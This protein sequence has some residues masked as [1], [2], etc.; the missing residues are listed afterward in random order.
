VRKETTASG[1][2]G[3]IIYDSSMLPL[4]IHFVVDSR[5]RE[6]HTRVGG[7][8]ASATHVPLEL[9]HTVDAGL[10]I[11]EG[12][13]AYEAYEA[14][15]A[16]DTRKKIIDRDLGQVTPCPVLGHQVTL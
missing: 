2:C 16:Y 4:V 5:A 15:E 14:C 10:T 3:V 6:P 9:F 1:L 12:N 7:F 11:N 8:Y 13:E